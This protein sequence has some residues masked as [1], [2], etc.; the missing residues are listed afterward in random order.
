MSLTR[1]D[2]ELSKDYKK[3]SPELIESLISEKNDNNKLTKY[4]FARHYIKRRDQS[5][6]DNPK[7]HG[8][9]NVELIQVFGEYSLTLNCFPGNENERGKE[10]DVNTLKSFY[11]FEKFPEDWTKAEKTISV[12][13]FW[14][15]RGEIKKIIKDLEKE[16]KKIKKKENRLE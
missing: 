15:L 13:Q 3:I 5:L 11:Q 4:S 1:P 7:F 12:Y 16:K 6:R 9:S 10:I 14:K 8:F 2:K